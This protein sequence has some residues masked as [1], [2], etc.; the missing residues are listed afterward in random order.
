[1]SDFQYKK[2]W[3]SIQARLYCIPDE[4]KEKHRFDVLHLNAYKIQLTPCDTYKF[5]HQIL[6][7]AID[8]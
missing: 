2:Y 3:K 7:N 6:K 5:V 1:M 8:C 4:D